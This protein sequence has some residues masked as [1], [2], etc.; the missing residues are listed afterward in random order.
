MRTL[1]THAR[2]PDD[3]GSPALDRFAVDGDRFADPDPDA[4]WTGW[5]T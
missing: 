3:V 2:L 5:W 1:Y 4:H